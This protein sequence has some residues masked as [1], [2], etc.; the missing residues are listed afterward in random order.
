M[1]LNKPA[2]VERVI[3][4][5]ASEVPSA[6]ATRRMTAISEQ[7]DRVPDPPD[8]FDPLER[9]SNGSAKRSSSIRRPTEG[10]FAF[11]DRGPARPNF[12]AYLLQNSEFM[13]AYGSWKLKTYPDGAP[14]PAQRSSAAA[15]RK[16]IGDI[17]KTVTSKPLTNFLPELRSVYFGPTE[18]FLSWGSRR[19]SGQ[20]GFARNGLEMAP[21]PVEKI[22]SRVGNG[23]ARKPRTY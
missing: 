21:Q 18:A 4:R 12:D 8:G 6:S 9:V 14:V 2:V 15:G 23:R 11:Y 17:R 22:E 16:K 3:D 10:R 20:N 5:L 7:N 13:L 1:G 19:D